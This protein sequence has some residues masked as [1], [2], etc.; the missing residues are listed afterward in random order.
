MT[1]IAIPTSVVSIADSAFNGCSK[2]TSVMLPTSITILGNSVFYGCSSLTNVTI[3]NSITAI[4]DL[5][6]AYCASLINI[7]IPSSVTS[8]GNS[9]FY[10]CSRLIG[11]Y[12]KG[13]APIVRGPPFGFNTTVYY[14]PNTTG[15]GST[16]GGRP[17]VLWNPWISTADPSFGVRTN[18]FGFRITG[19]K[20][21]PILVQACT[22]L[23]GASWTALQ[24]CTLT[25]GSIYFSDPAWTNY[26]GRFY[27]IRS[28]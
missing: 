2:L 20:N 21:I 19:T 24:S 6:F 9:T 25:N 17:C 15:W 27:R 18:R 3:G 10:Q 26:P 28:P 5:A 16:L 14:L 13:N 23:A 4:G 8:F 22:N 12:F 1:N 11:V 7:T